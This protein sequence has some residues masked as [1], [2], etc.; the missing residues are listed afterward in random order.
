MPTITFIP[1]SFTTPSD[2]VEGESEGA[3]EAPSNNGH[4]STTSSISGV[5]AQNK[6]CEWRGFVGADNVILTEV[7]IKVDYTKDGSFS[8]LGSN[9]FALHYS[10]DNGANYSSFFSS[11][12]TSGPSSATAEVALSNSQDLTQVRIADLI[13]ATGIGGGS[14][15]S[16]TVS[17]SNPRIELTF[18]P[19]PQMLLSSMM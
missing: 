18:D 19:P 13:R 8:A 3:V 6:S 1:A 4:A 10:T 11:T 17:I 16:L 12:D 15:A 5:G 7:K 2:Q 14:Q 9:F